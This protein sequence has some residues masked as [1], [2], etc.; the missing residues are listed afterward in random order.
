M[1]RKKKE[2]DI[3]DILPAEAFAEIDKLGYVF[4]SEQGYNTE[5]AQ[6][7]TELRT[8]L[9]NAIKKRGEELRYFGAVDKDSKAILVWFELYKGNERKAVSQSLKFIPSR[10]V[11]METTEKIKRDLRL[12]RKITHSIEVSLTVEKRHKERLEV[13]QKQQQTEEVK[14]NIADIE[15]VLAT[16]D[17]AKYIQR[18]TELESRYIE[19]INKLD[20]LDKTIILDGYVNGKAYWKIGRDIGYTEVGI[21]KRVNKIIEILAKILDKRV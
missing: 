2:I 16:L 14:Q 12:L 20:P 7:S 13:L 15:A 18:A 1:A 19:A 5:G 10:E 9:K 4:L 6:E 11:R 17:T 21:Q 8:K 3:F